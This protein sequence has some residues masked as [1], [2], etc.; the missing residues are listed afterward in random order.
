ML[1]SS[2]SF[3]FKNEYFLKIGPTMTSRSTTVQPENFISSKSH[4]N[5]E[6]SK[7]SSSWILYP[8]TANFFAMGNIFNRSSTD[9]DA[10]MHSEGYQYPPK[11]GKL[12]HQ[13]SLSYMYIP[14]AAKINAFVLQ[15]TI[16]VIPLL[17]VA[18]NLKLLS[19]NLTYLVKMLTWIF[20]A[21]D[22]FRYNFYLKNHSIHMYYF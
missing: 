4:E 6:A 14:K 5:K 8:W 2:N 17:W 19:Q 12:K 15:D 20:L 10:R 22:Q 16:L 3:F 11:T 9:S 18:K 13:F 21:I 1:S 7:F